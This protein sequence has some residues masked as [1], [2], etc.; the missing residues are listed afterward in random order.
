MSPPPPRSPLGILPGPSRAPVTI[1]SS[2][3]YEEV[4]KHMSSSVS[5]MYSIRLGPRGKCKQVPLYR[6][7]VDFGGLI[8]LYEKFIDLVEAVVDLLAN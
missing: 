4:S 5:T 7:I 3:H 6:G 2:A 8:D 1:V